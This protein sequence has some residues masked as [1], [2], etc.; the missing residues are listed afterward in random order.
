MYDRDYLYGAPLVDTNNPTV[1]SDTL[2]LSKEESLST[3]SSTLGVARYTDTLGV[4]ESPDTL[5]SEDKTRRDPDP[6]ELLRVSSP[7]SVGLTPVLN[8]EVR[9]EAIN[10]AIGFSSPLSDVLTPVNVS[11]VGEESPIIR[12]GSPEE[13]AQ[14]TKG[15]MWQRIQ[16]R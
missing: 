4:Y 10:E 5:P 8:T 12:S 14:T 3:D 16:S 13:D 2:V 7:L 11:E 1:T 15:I 9:E 6:Y